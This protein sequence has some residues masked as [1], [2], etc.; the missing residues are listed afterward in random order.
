MVLSYTAGRFEFF[1]LGHFLGGLIAALK[2]VLLIY[3][4]ECSPDDKRGPS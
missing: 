1:V 3:L 4:A 2:V